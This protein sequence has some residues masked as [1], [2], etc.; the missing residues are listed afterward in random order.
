MKKERVNIDQ[1]LCNHA[2]ILIAGGATTEMAA[3][4]L[5]IGQSTLQKIRRA[6]FD[7]EKYTALKQ[8]EKERMARAAQVET[9]REKEREKTPA[10][11]QC[12]GQL[13]M[14]LPEKETEEHMKQYRFLA[15]MVDKMCREQA[16]MVDDLCLKIDKLND[17]LSIIYRAIRKE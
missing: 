3:D 16:A 12:P 13:Q 9:S 15:A 1:A 17:T 4:M 7:A 10:E 11:E 8:Q 5:E 2:R 6:G 14:E